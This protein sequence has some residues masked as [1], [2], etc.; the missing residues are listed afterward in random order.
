M[1]H[2]S[3]IASEE[4]TNKTVGWFYSKLK[5]TTHMLEEIK[6]KQEDRRGRYSNATSARHIVP[7]VIEPVRSMEYCKSANMTT[8]CQEPKSSHFKIG[9][10]WLFNIGIWQKRFLFWNLM[11]SHTHK[12][13]AICQQCWEKRDTYHVC[14][15]YKT[16]LLSHVIATCSPDK[17]LSGFMSLCLSRF[18]HGF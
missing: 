14:K 12:S 15:N 9:I 6:K 10:G 4:D 2:H 17:V 8:K 18:S 13:Q 16:I 1:N 5:D 3:V 11:W 7:K